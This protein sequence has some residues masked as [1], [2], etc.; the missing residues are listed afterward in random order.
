ME[1]QRRPDPSGLIERDRNRCCPICLNFG[2]FRGLRL[3][4]GSA[5]ASQFPT[6]SRVVRLSR[7]AIVVGEIATSR[8]GF[9]SRT[10][11]SPVDGFAPRRAI[12]ASRCLNY[13]VPRRI[14]P[15]FPPPRFRFFFRILFRISASKRKS[16][17][18]ERKSRGSI[19][20]S[21]RVL[22]HSITIADEQVAIVSRRILNC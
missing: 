2:G 18:R 15:R 1:S 11:I 20:L 14:S 3:I 10:L 21:K 19:E 5:S 8:L 6:A 22:Y 9:R 16:D 7:P 12:Q 13:F 4:V 17:S